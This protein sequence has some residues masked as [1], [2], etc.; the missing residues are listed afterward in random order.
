MIVIFFQMTNINIFTENPIKFGIY[1]IYI[2]E[3]I[4]YWG[5][6]CIFELSNCAVMRAVWRLTP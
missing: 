1:L 4:E 3:G 6:S 2:V 5:K